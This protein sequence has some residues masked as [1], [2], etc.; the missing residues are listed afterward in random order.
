MTKQP[1]RESYLEA[2][3]DEQLAVDFENWI[4]TSSPK[5]ALPPCACA[6]LDGQGDGPEYWTWLIAQYRAS[7][8]SGD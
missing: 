4:L 7:A 1:D 5:T 3:D 6:V 2:V 8:I